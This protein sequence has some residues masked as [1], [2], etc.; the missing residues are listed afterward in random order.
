MTIR[1]SLVIGL[2]AAS[3]P[4]VDIHARIRPITDPIPVR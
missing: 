1:G 2:D 4:A 3:V